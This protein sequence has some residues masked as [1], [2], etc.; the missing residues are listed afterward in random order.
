[1][2]L[3]KYTQS[4]SEWYFYTHVHCTNIKTYHNISEYMLHSWLQ[5]TKLLDKVKDT[6]AR[7]GGALGLINVAPPN[8][9]QWA[10]CDTQSSFSSGCRDKVFSFSMLLNYFT[11]SPFL[12]LKQHFS[13]I[14][15]VVGP[16]FPLPVPNVGP[17][18]SS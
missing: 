18:C 9:S 1:M 4:R 14:Y 12:V 6:S 5:K 11:Q 8:C 10:A 15:V 17:L 3:R 13:N 16:L 2:I 7:K